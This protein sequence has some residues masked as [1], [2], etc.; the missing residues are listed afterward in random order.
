MIF[1]IATGILLAFFIMLLIR[2]SPQILIA[3]VLLYWLG[4]CVGP[5]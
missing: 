4:Q 1:A 3:L 2:Y 5:Q